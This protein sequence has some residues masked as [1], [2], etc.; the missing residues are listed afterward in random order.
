MYTSL[1]AKSFKKFGIFL[2]LFVVFFV[3]QSSAD[4]KFAVINIQKVTESCN[5]FQDIRKQME[6]RSQVLSGRFDDKIKRLQ[7]DENDLRKKKDVL[8]K[9]ALDGEI[10]KIENRKRQIQNESQEESKKLQKIYFDT[11]STMN[12]KIS[13]IIENYAKE[14]KINAIFEASGLIYNNI[15][16]IT[17]EII[18]LINKE[19]TSFKVDFEESEGKK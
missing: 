16:N 12:K 13:V 14:K 4:D 7:N 17:E 2:L 18:S 6:N 3:N 15:E 5:V 19:L 1:L 8:K 9:E 11:I 10:K